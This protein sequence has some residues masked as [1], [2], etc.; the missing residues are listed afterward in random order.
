MNG[1][2]IFDGSTTGKKSL[3]LHEATFNS[4]IRRSR[5]GILKN[6]KL[7]SEANEQNTNYFSEESC[8]LT[9]DLKKVN[10]NVEKGKLREIKAFN[11]DDTSEKSKNI[12]FE[13]FFHDVKNLRIG[14]VASDEVVSECNISRRKQDEYKTE[15]RQFNENKRHQKMILEEAE[16]E[17]QSI[18][19]F[20]AERDLN[21]ELKKDQMMLLQR[22]AAKRAI[23]LE[24]LQLSE[25]RRRRRFKFLKL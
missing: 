11:L 12:D 6:N 5:E 20:K 18:E 3:V 15:L 8:A 1:I 7:P 14:D 4:I 23:E 16:R 25:K 13:K 19:R 22:K 2:T 9:N 21:E 17:R 24:S 10:S